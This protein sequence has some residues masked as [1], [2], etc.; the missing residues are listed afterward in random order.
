MAG[1]AAPLQCCAPAFSRP[2]LTQHRPHRPECLQKTDWDLLQDEDCVSASPV[3]AR[4]SMMAVVDLEPYWTG[5]LHQK[6]TRVV[7]AT[8]GTTI[9]LHRC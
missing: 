8:Q 2:R 4:D 6:R 3:R 1:A 9:M 5:D 7:M